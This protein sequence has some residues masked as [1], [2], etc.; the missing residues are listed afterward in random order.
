MAHPRARWF[1][2]LGT[3]LVAGCSSVRLEPK[4][5][6][7]PPLIDRLPVAVAVHYPEEF[8][9]FSHKERRQGVDYEALLGAAHVVK[10]G[11]LLEAMF[12]RVTEVEEPARAAALEPR[13][14]FVLEPHFEEFAFLTPSDLAGDA[15][16][17]T[18]RY[19]VEVYDGEGGRVDGFVYTGFGRERAGPFGGT[20]ALVRATQRAMR[21]AAAKFA[22]EFTDQPAIRRLLAP[23]R[24]EA[25]P[26]ETQGPGGGGS[27]A[28]AAGGGAA[29]AAGSGPSSNSGSGGP[30]EESSPAEESPPGSAAG[31]ASAERSSQDSTTR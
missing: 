8:R 13:P 9:G 16:T 15:Y 5:E 24:L 4:G 17:V 31:G 18:I 11:R 6:V 28:G 12:E 27:S 20:E 1:A 21:D 7:P 23:G 22:I 26:V 2:L 30:A 25:L 14:L 3:V 29:P 10:F 19:R